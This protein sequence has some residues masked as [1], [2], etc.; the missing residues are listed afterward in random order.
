MAQ[1]YTKSFWKSF[2]SMMASKGWEKRLLFMRGVKW[3]K[4]K[5]EII[6]DKFGW[7]LNG[8]Q[9]PEQLILNSL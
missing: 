3:I 1:E 5:D 6:Y 2:D 4:A 7:H 9:V 8:K